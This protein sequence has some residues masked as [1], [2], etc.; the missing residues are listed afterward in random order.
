MGVVEVWKY[1]EIE[2]VYTHRAKVIGNRVLG[3]H[4]RI[5]PSLQKRR[6]ALWEQLAEAAIKTERQ[7]RAAWE[8]E[9]RRFVG[10]A[11]RINPSLF[12]ERLA[13]LQRASPVVANGQEFS[14]GVVGE[15]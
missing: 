15:A 13:P 1:A 12:D 14:F 3:F 4:D 2:G 8:G 5:D 9:S 6:A 10:M 7:R 11:K